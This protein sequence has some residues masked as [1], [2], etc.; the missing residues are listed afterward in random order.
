VNNPFAPNRPITT[1]T[2]AGPVST[3]PRPEPAGPEG[4]Q[5]FR[6][7]IVRVA[8]QPSTVPLATT[9]AGLVGRWFEPVTVDEDGALSGEMDGQPVPINA[10]AVVDLVR[11]TDLGAQL[12]VAVTAADV[13]AALLI[14]AHHARAEAERR[15]VAEQHRAARRRAELTEDADTATKRAGLLRALAELDGP[16][17][18][19]PAEP[20]PGPSRWRRHG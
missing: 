11:R 1:P 17:P 16:P 14:A 12:G 20:L 15:A 9:L 5:R 19:A 10:L 7:A 13:D 8:G 3:A 18:Q 2:G 4:D 6:D